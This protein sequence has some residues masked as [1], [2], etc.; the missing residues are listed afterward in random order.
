[1]NSS[2][3]DRPGS[4][5]VNADNTRAIAGAVFWLILLAIWQPKVADA[6][7][8]LGPLVIVPLGLRRLMALSTQQRDCAIFHTGRILQF[9]AAIVFSAG[10]M[11]DSEMARKWC[12]IPWT[13]VTSLFA[14][15]AVRIIARRRHMTVSE[16]IQ[17]AAM[18][19]IAVGGGWALFYRI[20]YRP[21]DFPIGIVKLT[22]IHFHYAGFA[23]PVIA[24][25]ILDSEPVDLSL[26]IGL[27][28]TLGIPLV[29]LG[30]TYSPVI[31][32][33]G[34]VVLALGCL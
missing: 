6:F 9:P 15:S 10:W 18:L 29:A 23:L 12:A 19:F 1:M 33:I 13:I 16:F 27:S 32:L 11:V 22:A 14:F 17:C 21:F 2:Q 5:A 30:I 31:E 34:A 24:A 25:E 28:I 4:I 20:E 26:A 8:L 3:A 7:L